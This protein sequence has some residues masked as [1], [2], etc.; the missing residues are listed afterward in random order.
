[1]KKQYMVRLTR[2]ERE[3]LQTLVSSG[4]AAA[5]KF[6]HARILLKADEGRRGPG[7]S[8]SQIADSLEVGLATVQRVRQKYCQKGLQAALERRPQS[9]RPDKRKIDGT[10]EAHLVALACSATPDGHDHWTLQLLADRL[11]A[12]RIVP[13]VSGQTVW[14]TLKKTN[15]SHG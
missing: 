4:Q 2:D 9:A 3:Q 14:R 6:V 12:L 1:M 8:D 10:A 7:W 13:A 11:V 15:S 5:R